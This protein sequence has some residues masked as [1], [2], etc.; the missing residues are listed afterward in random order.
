MN[1][2]NPHNS[3]KMGLLSNFV[4]EETERLREVNLSK[5]SKLGVKPGVG[6]GS[7]RQ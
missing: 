5:V 3:A 6:L 2:Q 1:S 4:N 7:C